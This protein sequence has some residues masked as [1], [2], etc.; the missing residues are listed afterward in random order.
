MKTEREL[1]IY[2]PK[3]LPFATY[4]RIA[5]AEVH[6]GRFL[7]CFEYDK[8]ADF[9]SKHYHVYREKDKWLSCYRLRVKRIAFAHHWKKW[10]SKDKPLF[11]AEYWENL[12]TEH[13]TRPHL[14]TI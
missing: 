10:H 2:N 11:A 4:W 6:L 9:A 13:N 3:V 7:P 8:A 1:F 12:W 5:L 14:K